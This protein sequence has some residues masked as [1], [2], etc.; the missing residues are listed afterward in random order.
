MYDKDELRKATE[1]LIKYLRKNYNPHVTVIVTYSSYELLRT[2]I[3][4]PEIYDDILEE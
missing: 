3:C 1:P 4:E 2:E